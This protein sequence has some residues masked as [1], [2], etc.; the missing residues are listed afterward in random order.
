MRE[1]NILVGTATSNS[2]TREILQDT[3]G[4]YIKANKHW[5]KL[6]TSECWAELS[7]DKVV[8]SFHQVVRL[9][10]DI[11][12]LRNLFSSTHNFFNPKLSQTKNYMVSKFFDSNCFWSEASLVSNTSLTCP[13]FNPHEI[14]LRLDFL[15]WFCSTC[16]DI[17]VN[18]Q[19]QFRLRSKVFSL[20]RL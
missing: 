9:G 6:F 2:P 5:N 3:I 12:S 20:E 10:Y 19:A 1:S 17:I 18:C 8:L 15:F 14:N 4:L 7:F 16:S 13:F 11:A